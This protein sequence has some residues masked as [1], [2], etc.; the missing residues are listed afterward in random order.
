VTERN[1]PEYRPWQYPGK[2]LREE[3]FWFD[4]TTRT[5]SA[6]VA[7]GVIAL[8]AV[9]AGI[10]TYEQRMDIL[11]TTG[12][13][14]AVLLAGVLYAYIYTKRY[15]RYSLIDVSAGWVTIRI[16]THPKL[17]QYTK[18][19]ILGDYKGWSR[20]IWDEHRDAI[21]KIRD[22][23]LS[24]DEKALIEATGKKRRKHFYYLPNPNYFPNAQ[25][26]DKQYRFREV[27]EEE[28]EAA[29]GYSGKQL[30]SPSS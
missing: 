19:H 12:T 17:K 9:V 23:L 25:A 11:R 8:A 14:A 24:L 5:L 3:K 16:G 1:E 10:G 30:S 7:A 13:V 22:E 26:P 2:W 21:E 15:R 4:I 20:A 18:Y 28:F 27:T 6:L 29:G